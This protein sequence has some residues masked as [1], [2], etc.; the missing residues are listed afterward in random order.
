MAFRPPS[1]TSVAA[2][3]AAA[4]HGSFTAAA[5]ELN[6]TQ[7]AVSH[8][9]K[10]LETRCGGALFDRRGRGVTLTAA[11]RQLASKVRLSMA[12]LGDAF[13]NE[14]RESREL[15]RITT[16]ASFAGRILLPLL[17]G[18]QQAWPHHRLEIICGDALA[19]INEGE[20]DL[21]IRFGPGG[22]ARLQ[23]VRLADE[24][25]FPVASPAYRN[26][27]LPS[28]PEDLAGCDLISHPDS[29]W[30]LWLEP[31][32]IDTEAIV[33][34]LTI[35]DAVLLLEAAKAGLGVALARA[36]LVEADLRS[37][38]LVRLFEQK[39]PAEYSYWC[40]WNAGSPK[41][42]SIESFVNLLTQA[43][44]AHLG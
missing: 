43:I 44:Q 26:G 17:P 35:N 13:G 40:V 10:G 19:D 1:L 7:S 20:A 31:L 33:P 37:G 12:L 9:I 39:V 11:G 24:W 4:R 27:N 25:L 18:I 2:F 5:R 28:L 23:S 36:A 15:L 42:A 22:W 29:A 34:A 38:K 14:G 3:E 32:G 16:L 21:G 8:A 30:R 41:R 6:L